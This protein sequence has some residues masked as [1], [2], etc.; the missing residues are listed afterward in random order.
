MAPRQDLYVERLMADY[1]KRIINMSLVHGTF[2]MSEEVV[3]D[4]P[5]GPGRTQSSA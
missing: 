2:A 1:N 4:S 5:R 3:E